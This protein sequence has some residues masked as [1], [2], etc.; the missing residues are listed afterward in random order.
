M[1]R[2]APVA[3]AVLAGLAFR[4]LVR[5]VRRGVGRAVR[6]GVGAQ[7][8]AVRR[9][10]AGTAPRPIAGGRAVAGEETAGTRPAA[11]RRGPGGTRSR[12]AGIAGSV[13]RTADAV[14]RA[15]H[16]RGG[17]R[18][19]VAGLVAGRLGA[20]LRPLSGLTGAVARAVGRGR[21]LVTRR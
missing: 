20:L 14:R 10:V 11:A 9:C 16:G 1:T 15:L 6:A 12:A 5:H 4:S 3:D 2:T 17:V 19:R 18:R 7:V 8:D 21:R 13:R